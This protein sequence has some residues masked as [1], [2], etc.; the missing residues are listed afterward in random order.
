MF[1]GRYVEADPVA[2]HT[3]LIAVTFGKAKLHRD[4]VNVI[5]GH[6]KRAI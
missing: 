4:V 3:L 6:Y 2:L 5:I 1:N